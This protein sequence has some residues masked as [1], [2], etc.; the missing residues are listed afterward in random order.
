M[1]TREQR[2]HLAEGPFFCDE[3]IT[4]SNYSTVRPNGRDDWLIIYTESGSGLVRTTDGEAA[5]IR[6]DALLFGPGEAQ[7]YR[8]NPAVGAWHLLWAHFNPSSETLIQLSWPRTD[9]GLRLLRLEGEVRAEFRTAMLRMLSLW[10]RDIP[11]SEELAI[12][13]LDSAF[14]WAAIA[15]SRGKWV[16]MDARVRR[17][18]DH[19]SA[20][21]SQPFRLDEL[22]RHCGVSVSRLAHL[23]K[24]ETG[25]PPQQYLERQRLRHASQLL[26]RTS[27][28]VA[29]V[30]AESGY[31]DPFYFSNRFRRSTG[32]SPSSFRRSG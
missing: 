12:N 20:N 2:S 5:A 15:D 7:D 19:L 10:K 6:G 24:S 22:A 28:T 32:E 1:L 3:F 18:I 26:R 16:S 21:L 14:L 4:A 11:N 27:L 31:P 8:T 25:V 30:A 13:A 23:F 17:A 9:C 29:E